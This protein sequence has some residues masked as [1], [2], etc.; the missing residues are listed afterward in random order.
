MFKTLLLSAAIIGTLVAQTP[1]TPAPT[2]PAGQTTPGPAPT[3]TG[4]VTPTPSAK[5]S[6]TPT[7][8]STP[9]PLPVPT[10]SPPPVATPM[11]VPTPWPTPKPLPTPLLLPADA[12]PQIVFVDI[13]DPV[14]RS[15]E[16]VSGT[17]ITSTNVAAV[18]IRIAG[19]ALRV[20]RADAGI[21]QMSY[22][23]PRIPFYM[24]GKYTGEI[25]AI[26]SAG[27]TA[28]QEMTFSVR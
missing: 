11:P 12:P 9:T 22:R 26:N 6:A 23:V 19:R 27:L 14:F 7:P 24:R 4:A 25:V 15:G 28:Q 1:P 10:I 18:E 20:P 16:I 17:V 2:P 21:W 5:P 8:L 3:P 13:S